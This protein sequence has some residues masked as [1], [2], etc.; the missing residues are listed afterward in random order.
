[1]AELIRE[2]RR[3]LAQFALAGHFLVT[4][5]TFV[6]GRDGQSL[7][8]EKLEQLVENPDAIDCLN[9]YV[10]SSADDEFVPLPPEA[11]ERLPNTAKWFAQCYALYRREIAQPFAERFR[12]CEAL[13][14]LVDITS[15]LSNG[16]TSHRAVQELL[17]LL[18]TRI[19]P[20][21]GV[22]LAL[23]DRALRIAY[24]GGVRDLGVKLKNLFPGLKVDSD[25]LANIRRL[26][27]VAT[28]ADKVHAV[29]RQN[30][31][32]L[33]DELVEPLRGLCKKG[34][35]RLLKIESFVCAALC[36]T[37]SRA[38]SVS[39]EGRFYR[40]MGG[41][42]VYDRMGKQRAPQPIL[43]P[44]SPLPM[45]WPKSWRRD[46]FLFTDVYPIYP[47]DEA[48]GPPHINLNLVAQFLLNAI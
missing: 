37:E 19:N 23:L 31:K 33:L 13:V 41:C 11:W 22:D 18:L 9:F 42:P 45:V 43:Y 25:A 10:G 36:A 27:F 1:G 12:D 39:A 40:E 34:F 28:K 17:K 48:S 30:V 24:P 14:V 29:D 6:V 16:P 21:Q 35:F 47:K 2:Y 38:E 46:D 20:G 26:A 15:I 8:R 32:L 44:V 4:P 5:S 3:A 7:K